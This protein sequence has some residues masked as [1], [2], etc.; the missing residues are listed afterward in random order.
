MTYAAKYL[1]WGGLALVSTPGCG[2]AQ[3]AKSSPTWEADVYPILQGRCL[4]CHGET[5]DRDGNGGRFDFYDFGECGELK[6]EDTTDTAVQKAKLFSV[7]LEKPEDGSRVYMPPAPASV[8]E[9]W[10]TETLLNFAKKAA[11]G[12][13][14]GSRNRDPRIII[15]SKLPNEVGDELKV[16]YRFEDTDGD[17]VIGVLKLG[18]AKVDLLKFSGQVTITGITGNSGDTLTLSADL[19]DGWEKVTVDDL[20]EVEKQ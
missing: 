17:P 1:L 7:F 8:L 18:D 20:G 6:L 2:P 12:S 3:E 13:R 15:T 11:R 16:S 5:A 4:H 9:D 10:E 14:S 19:C